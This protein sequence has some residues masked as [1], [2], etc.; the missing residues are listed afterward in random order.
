MQ[1]NKY[2]QRMKGKWQFFPRKKRLNCVTR[3]MTESELK[4]WLQNGY[5]IEDREHR[6]LQFV[7]DLKNRIAY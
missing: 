4:S 1:V 5:E 3:S 6:I 2:V 7:P